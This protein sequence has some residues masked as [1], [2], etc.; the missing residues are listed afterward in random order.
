MWRRLRPILMAALATMLA[1][2]PL[3]TL[4]LVPALYSLASRFTGARVSGPADADRP[5]ESG[6]APL[7][8]GGLLMAGRLTIDA[9][10]RR[11]RLHCRRHTAEMSAAPATTWVPGP[12]ASALTLPGPSKHEIAGRRTRFERD[13][14][15]SIAAAGFRVEASMKPEGGALVCRRRQ[16]H[17]LRRVGPH[18]I[19][20]TITIGDGGATFDGRNGIHAINYHHAT[21]G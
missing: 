3:L 10:S 2:A 11:V 1:L 8:R 12:P 21:A 16:M 14:W 9:E 18:D 15:S 6:A 17:V 13:G 4:V 19:Q 5:A 7:S 20:T